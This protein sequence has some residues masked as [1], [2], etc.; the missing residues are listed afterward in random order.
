MTNIRE[1]LKVIFKHIK[2]KL[3]NIYITLSQNSLKPSCFLI[4]R[5]IGKYVKFTGTIILWRA[6]NSVNVSITFEM[7]RYSDLLGYKV[8]YEKNA[9]ELAGCKW[10][11]SIWNWT[12]SAETSTYL[13]LGEHY[14][15]IGAL[16]WSNDPF[17]RQVIF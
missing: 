3:G 1:R 17:R 4:A 5:Q 10:L 9:R 14:D 2:S 15:F 13:T 6:F 8:L 11:I 16:L 12:I 7:R